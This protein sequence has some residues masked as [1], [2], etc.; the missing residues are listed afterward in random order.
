MKEIKALIRKVKIEK[1][2]RALE[3]VRANREKYLE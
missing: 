1:I 2:V 3:K